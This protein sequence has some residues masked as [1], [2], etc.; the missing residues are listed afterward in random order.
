[1][2]AWSG[3]LR[4]LGASSLNTCMLILETSTTRSHLPLAVCPAHSMNATTS[5]GLASTTSSGSAGH[6]AS[7]APEGGYCSVGAMARSLPRRWAGPPRWPQPRDRAIA[8]LGSQSFRVSLTRF[9]AALQ[10]APHGRRCGLFLECGLRLS[11]PAVMLSSNN[12][13]H[14]A[15]PQLNGIP[16]TAQ[17][18]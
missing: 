4:P 11:T 2:L 5:C 8:G 17:R 10:T 13:G 7:H 14:R 16:L 9:C 15:H 1:V 3:D 6:G 12:F 18:E